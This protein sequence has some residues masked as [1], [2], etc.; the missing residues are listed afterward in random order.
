MA[1]CEVI[2]PILK[3]EDWPH[4]FGVPNRIEYPTWFFREL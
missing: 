2:T 1:E 3:S 4:E